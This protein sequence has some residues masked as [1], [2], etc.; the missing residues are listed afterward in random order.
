MTGKPRNP[1]YIAGDNWAICDVC[2][3]AFRQADLK[4][5]WDGAVVCHQDWEVRH[6][7]DFLRA[8]KE[9]ISPSGHVRSDPQEAFLL[10]HAEFSPTKLIDSS[11]VIFRYLPDS[12][13]TLSLED[14]DEVTA[15]YSEPSEN[16]LSLEDTDEVTAKYSE[17][18][19]DSVSI[20][21]D[22]DITSIDRSI[23]IAGKAMAGVAIAG[24]DGN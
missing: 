16:T 14:T 23:A 22:F 17:E 5:R 7:Q 6:P 18:M 19:L 3:M 1:G 21:D 11:E 4:K 9:R 8:R 13:N 12:E 20:I 24:N 15:K 10:R 2:G